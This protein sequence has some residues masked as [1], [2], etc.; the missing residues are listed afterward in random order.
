VLRDYIAA[1]T[2][3]D[4]AVALGPEQGAYYRMRGVAHEFLGR[5]VQAIADYRTALSKNENDRE[6]RDRL[7]RLGVTP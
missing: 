2:D 6:A 5:R 1:F 7:K 4:R 3:F